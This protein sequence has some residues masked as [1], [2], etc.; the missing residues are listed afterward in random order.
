MAD[1]T[2]LNTGTMRQDLTDITHKRQMWT[3]R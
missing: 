3:I 1:E 2:W